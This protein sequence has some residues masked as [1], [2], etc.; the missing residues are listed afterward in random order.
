MVGTRLGHN[1][2]IPR[3]VSRDFFNIVC[4]H[5]LRMRGE[6]ILDDMGLR[7]GTAAEITTAAV[8]WLAQVEE[9]CVELIAD[10]ANLYDLW[11]VRL[12]S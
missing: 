1:P 6:Q 3:A 11:C 9:P 10:S 5:P 4:P 12:T 2:R 8:K 7:W